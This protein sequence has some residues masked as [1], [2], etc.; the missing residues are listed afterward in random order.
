MSTEDAEKILWAIE[1][2]AVKQGKHKAIESIDRWIELLLE[3]GDSADE[4]QEMKR[5]FLDFIDEVIQESKQSAT[6]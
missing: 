1:E 2:I 4:L 3:E 5:G 6:H